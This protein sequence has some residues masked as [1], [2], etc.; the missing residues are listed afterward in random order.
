[1]PVEQGDT[2]AEEVSGGLLGLEVGHGC[3]R[4]LTWEC[5]LAERGRAGALAE[6]LRALGFSDVSANA[7]IRELVDAEQHRVIVVPRTGR[8]QI[9][10]HYLTPYEARRAAARGVAAA[11]ASALADDGR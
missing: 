8:V 5:V 9:R 6:G 2:R 3:Y 1:M 11:L 10:V 4:H 7:L